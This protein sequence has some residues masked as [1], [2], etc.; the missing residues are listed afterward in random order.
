KGITNLGA[1]LVERR[2]GNA[3]ITSSAQVAEQI[4]KTSQVI[5]ISCVRLPRTNRTPNRVQR[6]RG[7]NAKL[8]KSVDIP[9]FRLAETSGGD[10]SV[11]Q[12]DVEDRQFENVRPAAFFDFQKQHGDEFFADI[13][14]E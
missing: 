13:N 5:S 6:T 1:C 7:P 12:I 4:G 9:G 10:A 14:F 8:S 2:V 3:D 11:H